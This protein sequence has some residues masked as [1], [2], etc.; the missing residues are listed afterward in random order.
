MVIRGYKP[1]TPGIRNRY[2]SQFKEIF[3]SVPYRKLI[4][5]QNRKKGRNNRGVITSRH[6]GGGHK[7]L[8]RHIDFRRDKKQIT[9]RIVS[10]EYDPNRNARICLV[11]YEDGEK[12]YILH[13][14]GVNIEDTVLAST[15]AP[16]LP[17]N[18]L[19]LS[20]V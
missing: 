14:R 8:Y 10:I 5:G 4:S 19:P 9:G 20:A 12:R 11:A 1:Y 7:R 3:S 6:R 17:G 15:T 13:P 2:I 18:A 16:I